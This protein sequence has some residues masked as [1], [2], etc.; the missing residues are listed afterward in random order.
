[1]NDR[2]L[3]RQTVQVDPVRVVA[4]AID[5]R[6][7]KIR[8]SQINRRIGDRHGH[9][10]L[11]HAAKKENVSKHDGDHEEIDPQR[12]VVSQ[13]IKRNA[14]HEAQEQVFQLDPDATGS[15]VI[16]MII[17]HDCC[18]R[19]SENAKRREHRTCVAPT[20]ELQHRQ[21]GQC[22]VALHFRRDRPQLGVDDTGRR[23]AEENAGK[24]IMDIAEDI[25]RIFKKEIIAEICLQRELG[26][27][28]PENEHCQ[29]RFDDKRRK[30]PQCPQCQKPGSRFRSH[31]AAG[32][33]KP[34]QRKEGR[35]DCPDDR[36]VERRVGDL[37]TANPRG[38]IR[39]GFESIYI[40]AERE[41]LAVHKQ[42]QRR[43]NNS[44]VVKSGRMA[45]Y[46]ANSC[47]YCLA[48]RQCRITHQ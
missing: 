31:Q 15:P 32:N 22:N 35:H 13:I 48:V 19:K 28:R 24:E 30:D 1:M 10:E 20:G 38:R 25:E 33:E 37:K 21:A 3:H 14:S 8:I 39:Q 17:S 29:Q 43:K 41:R 46:T 16:G 47:G 23:I 9:Q 36:L 27:E 12:N 6:L 18:Q 5:D 45:F 34:A 7:G 11:Q 44:Q 4:C 40:N 26:N 2:L 42:H